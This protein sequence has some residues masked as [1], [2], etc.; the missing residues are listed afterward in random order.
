MFHFFRKP[1]EAK[2]PSAP[3]KEAD[4]FVLLGDTANEQRA[5]ARGETSEVEGNQ[6]YLFCARHHSQGWRQST[7]INRTDVAHAF[8]K[9]SVCGGQRRPQ[10]P[11]TVCPRQCRGMSGPSSA[12]CRNLPFLK[13]ISI[14][15]SWLLRQ[16]SGCTNLKVSTVNLLCRN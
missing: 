12:K 4:G 15:Y 6:P 16:Q 13:Y 11:C 10:D 9:L 8:P 2:A 7:I 3:E 1:P 14:P 5:A